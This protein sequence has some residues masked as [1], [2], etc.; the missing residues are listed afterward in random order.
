M[1]S[2]PS[3]AIIHVHGGWFTWGSALAFRHLACHIAAH[4]G[5]AVFL[6]DYRLAPEHPFPAAIED[7]RA[8]YLGMFDRGY[9]KIAITGDSAGG[10]LAF[11]VVTKL[12]ADRVPSASALVGGVAL[13]PVTDLSLR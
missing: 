10:N 6:P 2:A 3:H 12:A 1:H 13:S 4:A 9:S 8:Y 7:F 11:G 5:T